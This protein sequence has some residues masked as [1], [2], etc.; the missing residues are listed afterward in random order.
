MTARRHDDLPLDE[1]TPAEGFVDTE[2]CVVLGRQQFAKSRQR[3]GATHLRREVC[4]E[5]DTHRL[6][7]RTSARPRVAVLRCC[8]VAGVLAVRSAPPEEG[9]VTQ[10]GQPGDQPPHWLPQQPGWGQQQPP[11]GYGYPPPGYGSYPPYGYGPPPNNLG[12]AIVALI[13]FWPLAIPAFISYSKVE[14]SYYRGDIAGALRASQDVKK[15]G[16]IALIVGIA[17]LVFFMIFSF[18]ILASFR[19]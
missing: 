4:R 8:G 3:H 12:W 9:A 7:L 1:F 10:P 6:C 15:F 16:V 18:A 11:P 19:T 13:V 2:S 17:V 14:S 5:W